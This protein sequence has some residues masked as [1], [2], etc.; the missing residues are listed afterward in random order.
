M[1]LNIFQHLNG[2]KLG[3]RLLKVM[4]NTGYF[5]S[6]SANLK[7][8]VKAVVAFGGLIDGFSEAVCRQLR[9]HSH[10]TN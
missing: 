2:S 1:V 5:D 9:E 7:T 4:A 3:K 8:G 10:I 6:V